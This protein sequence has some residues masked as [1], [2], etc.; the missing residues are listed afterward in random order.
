MI[1]RLSDKQ[2]LA[3]LREMLRIRIFEEQVIRLIGLKELE[4]GFHLLMGHESAVVG[5]SSALRSDDYITSN[6]RT[7]GRY[8]ARGGSMNKIMAEIFGKSTGVCEGKAGEML[9]ADKSCGFL[10][11]S[12]T[13]SAGIPVAAG[14]GLAIKLLKTDQVVASFFGDA[15]SGNAPFHEALNIAATHKAPVIFVCENNGYSINVR[16][17]ELMSTKTIAEKARAYAIPGIRVDGSDAESVYGAARQAVS[18][19][20]SGKGPTLL[21]VVTVRLRP[22]KEGI[23]DTRSKRE[24]AV[25]WKRDPVALYTNK[26][27]KLG[28]LTTA[29]ERDLHSEIESEVASATEFARRSE[30]PDETK[31]YDELYS[32]KV[33]NLFSYSMG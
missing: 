3:F 20:R 28:V 7:L 29:A 32:E 9:I 10:F 6:H 22:H 4:I 1:M 13:V 23:G 12:V 15:A 5:V 25:A 26:L 16:T 33:S 18:R 19:A 2:R 31:L 24:L 14:A 17:S 8:L 11:S 27:R 21:E 30:F